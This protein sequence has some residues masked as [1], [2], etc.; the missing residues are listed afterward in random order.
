M[1]LRI[2]LLSIVFFLLGTCTTQDLKLVKQVDPDGNTEQFQVSK[3][4]GQRNGFYQRARPDGSF[5]EIANYTE[6]V[7][8]GRRV[9]FYES[10]DTMII[11]T[12]RMGVFDG[13]YRSFYKDGKLKISGYYSDNQMQGWWEKFYPSG[14]LM[15]KVT[16]NNNLENGP[17]IEY[18]ENGKVS[19]EGQYINGD[20]DHGELKFYT[21]DGTHY[22]SM[23]C[24]NGLCKTSWRLESESL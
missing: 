16:F 19:V 1:L 23:L 9:L 18:H 24:D 10:M 15:E 4:S 21:E 22:K 17:F 20:N 8:N 11:E 14:A 6:G 13:L 12:H 7:L 5:I 2:F 3:E